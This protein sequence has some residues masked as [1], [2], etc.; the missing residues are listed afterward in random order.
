MKGLPYHL[1]T[2]LPTFLKYCTLQGCPTLS[3]G[4]G[5][6]TK[7]QYN[8]KDRGT[9]SKE[10]PLAPSNNTSDPG[11]QPNNVASHFGQLKVSQPLP[12]QHKLNQEKGIGC[13]H[14]GL[15]TS[16]NVKWPLLRRLKTFAQ[17]GFSPGHSF[18]KVASCIAVELREW[19]LFLTLRLGGKCLYCA[20]W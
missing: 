9:S 3:L 4:P 13:T 11:S 10:T 1:P 5:E 19:P 7:N 2:K 8:R 6:R 15:K 17:G 18:G 20:T 12:I 14:L 16:Q